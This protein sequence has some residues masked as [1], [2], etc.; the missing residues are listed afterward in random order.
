MSDNLS[1]EDID[2]LL[3]GMPVDGNAPGLG[4]SGEMLSSDEKDTLGEICNISMGASATT[5]TEILGNKVEIALPQVVA[6]TDISEIL[7]LQGDSTLVEIK[8]NGG[9]DTTILLLLKNTDVAVIADLMMGGTGL[10]ENVELGEVQLNSVVEAMNQMMNSA[11]TNLAS[12]FEMSVNIS[13][14]V[15]RP[16]VL[17]QDIELPQELQNSPVVGV[18]FKLTLGDILD[19]ELI[20]IMSLDTAQKQV[21]MFMGSVD[22]LI[23]GVSSAPQYTSVTNSAPKNDGGPRM[24]GSAG[25]PQEESNFGF[26][27]QPVTVQPAK[28]SSFDNNPAMFGMENQ[29]LELV[30]DVALKLTVELG[31]SELPIKKV[32]ELTRGSVIELDKIAGEP[33]DLFANGKLIAKGEVVVIEDNFGLR[34][35]SIISPADRLKNL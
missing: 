27:Q 20:Q 25:E 17:E 12:I 3:A 11:A 16:V 26:N 21:R 23:Q 33:V 15:V 28:F 22:S 6:Y 30:L 7:T 24:F 32:L 2:R 18:S 31:R 4:G 9:L 5:L 14:P 13:L 8:Y 19:S 29:N 10:T 1:Q 35:T 34:I